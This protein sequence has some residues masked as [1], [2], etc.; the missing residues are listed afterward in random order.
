MM[1]V[2]DFF[3]TILLMCIICV[4]VD[5]QTGSGKTFTMLGSEENPGVNFRSLS[6]L[7]SLI[8]KRSAT[9]VYE[10]SLS[11][12]DIYN[13]EIRDLLSGSDKGGK[14]CK[15]LDVK[16]SSETKQMEIAGNT[17]FRRYCH[18]I[19]LFYHVLILLLK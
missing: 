2:N 17:Y 14:D 5:G 6:T 16:R 7:F 4:H 9:H 3:L 8:E 13:N 10:L 12:V 1:A 11:V 18:C 15:V 19:Y